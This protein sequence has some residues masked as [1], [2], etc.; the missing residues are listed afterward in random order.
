MEWTSFKCGLEWKCERINFKPS[1]CFR[2]DK[3]NQFYVTGIYFSLFFNIFY[4]VIYQTY[5]PTKK[6]NNIYSTDVY[7]A[8]HHIK[9]P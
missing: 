1:S 6:W 4:H 9:P 7:F 2:N 8:M 5:H 3:L